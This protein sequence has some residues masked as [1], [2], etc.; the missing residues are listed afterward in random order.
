MM[1]GLY[2]SVEQLTELLH[3]FPPE[4]G[5]LRIM[6]ITT[7]FAHLTDIENIYTIVDDVLTFDERNEVWLLECQELFGQ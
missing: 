7:V 3:Y 2:F 4:V 5:Y 1:P 6:L